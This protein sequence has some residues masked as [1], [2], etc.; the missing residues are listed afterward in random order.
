LGILTW[1]SSVTSIPLKR[2]VCVTGVSGSGKSA[3]V[4]DVL[5]PA[6][7]KYRGKPAHVLGD[8]ASK[9]VDLA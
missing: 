2:P 3:L 4:D 9:C 8:L 6:L 7:L 1:A 5:H